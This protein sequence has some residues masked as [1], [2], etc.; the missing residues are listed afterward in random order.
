MK[1]R[2]LFL[3]LVVFGLTSIINAHCEVP[4]GI[5]G[6]ELRIKLIKEHITT[7]EKAINQI[8]SLQSKESV[9]YN[10]L[11]RWINNKEKHADEI[12]TIVSKYFLTQRIK[13]TADHYED[14]LKSLHSI[15]IYAMKCKQSLKKENIEEIK[16]EVDAFSSLYFDHKH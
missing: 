16:K 7:I 14:K 15:L 3:L 8:E 6:D 1:K 9:N 5:Y 11:V 12:Q 2:I 13:P 4:C 10:Q